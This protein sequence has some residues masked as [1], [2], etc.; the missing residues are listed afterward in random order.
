[1][2]DAATSIRS[3]VASAWLRTLFWVAKRAP[4]LLKVFRPVVAVGVPIVSRKVRTNTRLNGLRVAADG[5][6]LA[7]SSAV[8]GAFFDF[9]AEVATNADCTPQGVRGRVVAVEGEPA[10]LELRKQKR[11]AV[12]VTAHMGSF[13]VGLAA[14]ST[15]EPKIHVVFKR[16]AHDG[17]ERLRRPL[18]ERLGVAEC[19]ID[20]GWPALIGLRDAL[21]RNEVVVMQADRAMPGQKSASV[22]VGKGTLR[23][24]VGPVTLA[25][26]NGSPIVPV[27][28]VRES[29]GRYRIFLERAIDP[30][31]DDA[32]QQVG[33]ALEKFITRYPRQWLVL[34]AAFV[35]DAKRGIR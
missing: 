13:E 23:I 29:P 21:R 11:G 34:D 4:G 3:R 24:P 35:E 14:L 31:A 19:P 15:V 32:V 25:R 28:A 33:Q 16:D 8:T 2:S 7:F 10:Y 12:L 5:G 6:S 1:M 27:F 18:R 26:I 9:V 30:S 22:K 20:D 17:F